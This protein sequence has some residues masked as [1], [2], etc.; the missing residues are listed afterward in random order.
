MLPCRNLGDHAT[1]RGVQIALAGNSFG[2]H[3]ATFAYEGDRRLIA[4]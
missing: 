1:S 3:L 2:E 4:A